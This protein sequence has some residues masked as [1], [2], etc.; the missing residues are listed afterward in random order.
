[1]GQHCLASVEVT[2]AESCIW[3]KRWAL[4]H[5][6]R[7]CLPHCYASKRSSSAWCTFKEVTRPD[8]YKL[9]GLN[10]R[11]EPYLKARV[12]IMLLMSEMS[13]EGLSKHCKRSC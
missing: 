4:P 8:C 3:T 5:G 11:S 10:G 9:Q 2:S 13:T 1:M 7:W 12:L 6:S